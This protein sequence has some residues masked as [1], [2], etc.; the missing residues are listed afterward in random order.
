M[1]DTFL[2]EGLDGEPVAEIIPLYL[3]D[4]SGYTMRTYPFN[5]PWDSGQVGFIVATRKSAKRIGIRHLTQKSR[6]K[7]RARL[8]G[9]V[10]EYDQYLT[11]DVY[12][13]IIEDEEGEMV[14]ACWGFYGHDHCLKEA[15][16]RAQ[17][18]AKTRLRHNVTGRRHE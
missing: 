14:D 12:G 3:Y 10:T 16:A 6:E 5:C 15:N 4:H 13:F 9:E 2:R 8:I 17:S 18:L 1:E 11:G 7:I